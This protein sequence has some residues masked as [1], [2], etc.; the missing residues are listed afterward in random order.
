MGGANVRD[1]YAVF[2]ASKTNNSN[3]GGLTGSPPALPRGLSL[4]V[5]G[6]AITIAGVEFPSITA[7]LNAYKED[8]DVHIISTPQIL[9]TDNQ[10]AQIQVG[11]NVPYITSKNT[12]SGTQQDYTNYEY[13]DVGVTLKITPQI[14]WEGVVRMRIFTEI[15]KLKD[16][17]AVTDTPTTLKRT[18]DT[19]VIV[20]DQD[21]VVIG[22]II[23]DDIQ[24]NI[25]KVPLLGDI[26]LFGWLFKS[27][28]TSRERTN[29]YIFLT[30][31][32][33]RNPLDAKKIYLEKK[34]E[35]DWHHEKGFSE[36][37]KRR[38]DENETAKLS[39]LGFQHL[40]AREYEMAEGYF[41]RVLTLN[42]DDPETLILM[43]EVYEAQDN[44]AQAVILYE[45]VID[46][47][48]AGL[49]AVTV[50]PGMQGRNLADIAREH[51]ER[52]QMGN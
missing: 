13:K 1:Q 46:L 45:K 12:T 23:G 28:S 9:T 40:K 26:P 31:R 42:P 8:A 39:A 20:Q 43:G 32:I 36:P 51:L 14:N 27:H 16:P 6:K 41:E 11:Q 37:F 30:P 38:I 48:P 25:Y 17:D 10:E 47:K 35:S 18:A 5:V 29:L 34:E 2:G 44:P 50:D 15:I 49:A 4:G 22:G 3:L 24:E 7:V 33:I 21:T 52:L 19:T